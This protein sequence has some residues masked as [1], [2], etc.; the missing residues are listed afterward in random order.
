MPILRLGVLSFGLEPRATVPRRSI[1]SPQDCEGTLF[2]G[3]FMDQRYRAAVLSRQAQPNRQPVMPKACRP[4]IGAP[5]V[6]RGGLAPLGRCGHGPIACR[7]MDW[8]ALRLIPGWVWRF[9]V[10]RF[11]LQGATKKR[12]PGVGRVRGWMGNSAHQFPAISPMLS[13]FSST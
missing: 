7:A 4:F 3:R 9:R 12:A 8:R 10:G 11:V 6:R 5:L 2:S 13:S 1:E